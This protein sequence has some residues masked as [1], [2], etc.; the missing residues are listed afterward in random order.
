MS[1]IPAGWYDDGSGTQRWWDGYAW[2]EDVL[3][4]SSHRGDGV[5]EPRLRETWQDFGARMSARPDPAA[6]GD[7]IWGAVS[8]P[9]AGI[10]GGSYK[11]TVDYLIVEKGI[12]STSSQQIRTRD[13]REVSASQ[14]MTQKVREVGHI[15]VR[16][17]SADGSHNVT[18]EDVPDFR[19]GAALISRAADQ[20]Q[21][22]E[23]GRAS[24]M[25]SGGAARQGSP[26][27]A[28]A[29]DSQPSPSDQRSA[30]MGL[31]TELLRLAQLHADGVLTDEEFAAAKAKL[32]GL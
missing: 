18:L 20:A 3:A 9:L 27:V 30:A 24:S 11:L 6:D 7:A 25:H 32:L 31:N 26:H 21:S 14:N 1:D 13:I 10:G 29:T 23:S 8:K 4:D 12:F 22:E 19:Q 16:A 15:I 17:S 5:R 28:R 2:T